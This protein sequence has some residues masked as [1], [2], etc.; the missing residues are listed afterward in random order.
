MMKEFETSWPEGF[1]AT[2]LKRVVTFE[3]KTKYLKVA[4]HDVMNPEEIYNQ[5]LGL[6]VS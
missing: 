4:G 2:I 1:Y 5:V 3:E 6:L